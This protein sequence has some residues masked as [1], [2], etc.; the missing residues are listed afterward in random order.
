M[1]AQKGIAASSIGPVLGS[2][3]LSLCII[4]KPI[5]NS[6]VRV[7]TLGLM[8]CST[9]QVDLM[10]TFVYDTITLLHPDT[11]GNLTEGSSYSFE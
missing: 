10:R 8:G 7:A 1:N 5:S 11:Q 9:T 6:S 4:W 3:I 2:E